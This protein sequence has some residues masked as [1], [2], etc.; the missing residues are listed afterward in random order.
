MDTGRLIDF[1]R[2]IF[3]FF[4][5]CVICFWQSLKVALLVYGALTLYAL[6]DYRR[7]NMFLRQSQGRT[8]GNLNQ[9]HNI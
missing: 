5:G 1:A 8:I 9:L 2:M 4:S 3:Q 6:T 7:I